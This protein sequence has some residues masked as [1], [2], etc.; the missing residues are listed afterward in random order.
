[1][2]F[3]GMF[4]FLFWHTLPSIPTLLGL[5]CHNQAHPPTSNSFS[6]TRSPSQ[7]IRASHAKGFIGAAVGQKGDGVGMVEGDTYLISTKLNRGFGCA[8]SGVIGR[9][10]FR[11]CVNGRG[12]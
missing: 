7:R 9:D 1:M 8:A 12:F 5:L 2:G 4:F 10:R 6:G 11:V 3:R